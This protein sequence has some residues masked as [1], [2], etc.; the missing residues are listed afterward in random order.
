MD[1]LDI[2]SLGSSLTYGLSSGIT[3]TTELTYGV[4]STIG[5]G[6]NLTSEFGSG[7]GSMIGLGYTSEQSGSDNEYYHDEISK[8]KYVKKKIITQNYYINMISSYS[9]SI[10]M[11]FIPHHT[12]AYHVV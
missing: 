8:K 7:I 11:I 4:G 12:A 10:F 1:F 2:N 9:R 5:Y 3:L 6:L